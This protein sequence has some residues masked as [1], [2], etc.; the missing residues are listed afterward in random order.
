MFSFFLL[1]YD[2]SQLPTG[3]K[4]EVLVDTSNLSAG[5]SGRQKEIEGETYRSTEEDDGQFLIFQISNL[6][7][8]HGLLGLA[9][10][11]LE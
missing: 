11:L 9:W 5:W 6:S 2:Y 10:G 3:V 4:S 7:S 1:V 8:V